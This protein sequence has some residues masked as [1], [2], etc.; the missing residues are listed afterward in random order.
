MKADQVFWD[1][2]ELVAINY[3]DDLS[4]FTALKKT[5]FVFGF[6]F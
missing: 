3:F 2:I 4:R 6:D 5:V 1:Q